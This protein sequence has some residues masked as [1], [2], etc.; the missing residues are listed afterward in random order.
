MCNEETEAQSGKETGSNLKGSKANIP[1]QLHLIPIHTLS[2]YSPVPWDSPQQ[3][4]VEK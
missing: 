3:I 4:N 2:F 1:N